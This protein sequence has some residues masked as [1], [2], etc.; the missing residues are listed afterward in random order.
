MFLDS[1]PTVPSWNTWDTAISNFF[2]SGFN[3]AIPQEWGGSDTHGPIPSLRSSLF[4]LN[5]L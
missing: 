5:R 3:G 4:W 2:N 1:L